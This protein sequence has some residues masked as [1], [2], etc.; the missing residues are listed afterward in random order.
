MKKL[1]F[2]TWLMLFAVLGSMPFAHAGDNRMTLTGSS[3]VAPLASE[4]AK[5]YESIHPNVCID[6]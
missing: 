1:L 2:G 3:T 5:R 4:I 6:V